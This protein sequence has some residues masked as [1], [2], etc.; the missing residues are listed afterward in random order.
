[1]TSFL[2]L[3]D[4]R[5]QKLTNEVANLKRVTLKTEDVVNAVLFLTSEEGRSVSGHSILIDGGLVL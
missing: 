4:E 2:R 3:D 5:L 1:D